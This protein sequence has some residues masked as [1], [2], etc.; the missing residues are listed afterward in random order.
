[1]GYLALLVAFLLIL[2]AGACHI[3]RNAPVM[4]EPDAGEVDAGEDDGGR[5]GN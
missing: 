5:D 2:V 4:D 3:E 1:M